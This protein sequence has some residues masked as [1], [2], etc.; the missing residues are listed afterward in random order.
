MM[1]SLSETFEPRINSKSCCGKTT[2]CQL[3]KSSIDTHT[4]LLDRS[5]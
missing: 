3:A 5:I 1:D 2:N 4:N